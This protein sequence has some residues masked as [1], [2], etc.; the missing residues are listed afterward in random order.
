MSKQLNELFEKMYDNKL[1]E[2]QI[3]LLRYY[4]GVDEVELTE[5][6]IKEIVSKGLWGD[7]ESLRELRNEGGKWN[8]VRHSVTFPPQTI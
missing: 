6:L 4:H 2:E 8:T 3:E 5:E 1:T 7:E